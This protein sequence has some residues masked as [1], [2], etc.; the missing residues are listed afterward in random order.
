MSEEPLG[1]ARGAALLTEV[2]VQVWRVSA[3]ACRS[4]H[5]LGGVQVAAAEAV[6]VV[7]R[8]AHRSASH[9][10]AGAGQR[11][12]ARPLPELLTHRGP[13]DRG[14]VRQE[15]VPPLPSPHPVHHHRRQRPHRGISSTRVLDMVGSRECPECEPKRRAAWEAAYER[16]KATP[17]ADVPALLAAWADDVDPVRWRSPTAGHNTGFAARKDTIRGC[18]RIH[19]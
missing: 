6:D 19:A 15:P 12:L 2:G 4:E 9:M 7:S 14:Q 13:A 5:A 8:S 11:G 3:S 1:G 10:P 16:Y 17:V 18:R